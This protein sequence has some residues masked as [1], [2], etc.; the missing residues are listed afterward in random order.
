MKL[1]CRSGCRERMQPTDETQVPAF[2]L[3]AW[4]QET[5][6]EKWVT[7][8]TSVVDNA[9]KTMKKRNTLGQCPQGIVH[10]G[11]KKNPRQVPREHCVQRKQCQL[12]AR[13]LDDRI[14]QSNASKGVV[15]R[16]TD[17]MR[18]DSVDGCNERSTMHSWHPEKNARMP[19]PS[20]ASRI[21][22]QQVLVLGQPLNGILSRC[23]P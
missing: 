21:H 5:M 11:G 2:K 15:I 3:A 6:S 18:A 7:R 20:L 22:G 8:L 14:Y 17:F 9:P 4:R 16:A 13:H 1:N 23:I 19:P 10:N 12:L